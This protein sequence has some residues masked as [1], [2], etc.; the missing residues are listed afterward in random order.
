V[1]LREEAG[2]ERHLIQVGSPA[3][4]LRSVFMQY[5]PADNP[6]LAKRFGLRGHQM[7]C[8]AIRCRGW[9]LRSI[10]PPTTSACARVPADAWSSAPPIGCD[11]H[12]GRTM[13]EPCGSFDEGWFVAEAEMEVR[14]TGWRY[15]LP[16]AIYPSSS[17]KRGTRT[18][19]TWY[20]PLPL[21]AWSH[22]ITQ[23][24]EESHNRV[25]TAQ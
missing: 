22:G 5:D 9:R 24:A 10:S 15:L 3:D 21:P 14:R 12:W 25:S 8:L 16:I 20:T 19:D 7:G 17:R 6:A 1:Q 23:I 4:F 11:T 2:D 13:A 18:P